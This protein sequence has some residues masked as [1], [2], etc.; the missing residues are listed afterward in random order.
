MSPGTLAV[1]LRDF[2][3]RDLQTRCL[4]LAKSPL[5]VVSKLNDAECDE[6]DPNEELFI[7][8]SRHGLLCVVMLK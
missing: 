1:H 6:I 2:P 4:T 8:L 3:N 7:V 5:L